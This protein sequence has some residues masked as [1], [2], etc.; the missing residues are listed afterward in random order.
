MSDTTEII[1]IPNINTFVGSIPIGYELCVYEKGSS[2]PATDGYHLYGFDEVGDYKS[3]G[4][5]SPKYCFVRH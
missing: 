3:L 4:I 1:E 5:K 2:N